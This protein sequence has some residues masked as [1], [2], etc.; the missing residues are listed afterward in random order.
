M[1]ASI[2][3]VQQHCGPELR[4]FQE[5]LDKTSHPSNCQRALK[6]LNL[7]TEAKVPSVR[8]IREQ[9]DQQNQA[10]SKCMEENANTPDK[11]IDALRSF[12]ECAESMRQ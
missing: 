7:C 10:F 11:C 6:T 12:Y 2:D 9:C 1:E 8:R 3:E 5:C 4:Q